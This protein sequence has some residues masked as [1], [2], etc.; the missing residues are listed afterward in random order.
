MEL[1]EAPPPQLASAPAL[2]TLLLSR[3]VIILMII[4]YYNPC[5]SLPRCLRSEE[6]GVRGPASYGDLL[7]GSPAG[8]PSVRPSVPKHTCPP[9]PPHP[10]IWGLSPTRAPNPDCPPAY[11]LCPS[12]HQLIRLAPAPVLP[13][14][15]PKP[16]SAPSGAAPQ[17]PSPRPPACPEP[18]PPFFP[19][20]LFPNKSPRPGQPPQCLLED[21]T[22]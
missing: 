19:F 8:C 22:P 18:S 5:P 16:F 1:A 12:S 17:A 21:R 11:H 3:C 13:F 6:N 15:A 20:S 9:V 2:I 4:N 7:G 14:S 10:L